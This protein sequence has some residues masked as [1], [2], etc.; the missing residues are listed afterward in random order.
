MEKS[1]LSVSLSVCLSDLRGVS[2]FQLGPETGPNYIHVVRR[3]AGEQYV[4]GVK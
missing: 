3:S 4:L 2:E 1:A